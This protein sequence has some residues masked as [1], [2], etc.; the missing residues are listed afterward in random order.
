[1]SVQIFYELRAVRFIGDALG[2]EQDLFI[3]CFLSGDSRTYTW[4]GKRERRWS[5]PVMGS[6]DDVMAHQ[7][8]WVASEMYWKNNGASGCL[9]DFQWLTKVR[10]ALNTATIVTA[11]PSEA[12]G[13]SIDGIGLTPH[14]RCEGMTV[15]EAIDASL[16][17]REEPENQG[18]SDWDVFLVQGP[19]SN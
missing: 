18:R 8:T 9:Q 13:V 12:R 10:K 4:E 7:L 5:S 11:L 2:R 6:F 14:R 16:T 15:R 19:G 3:L 1:M 17:L